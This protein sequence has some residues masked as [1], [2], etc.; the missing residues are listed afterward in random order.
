MPP[1]PHS[2]TASDRRWRLAGLGFCVLMLALHV[3]AGMN[4][5]GLSDFWRDFYWATAIAHGEAFPLAGPQIYQ[6]FEL[7][8][9]WFYL[10]ALPV[11]ATGS[12]ALTM[13]FVQALASL[14]YFL[15]WRIGTRLVDARFG[16]V[17]AASL[18]IA[19]WSLVGL[20]FPSHV[21]LIETTL[22]LLAL[23]VMR[24]AR[25]F[26][27]VEAVLFGLAAAAC[28]HAHPTTLTYVAAAGLFLLWRHRS[29]AVFGWLCVAA[30]IVL[31]S[32]LPPWLHRDPAA[33][34][35]LKPIGDYV[36]GD[37]GRHALAR[38]P[39]VAWSVLLGG[40]WWELLLMTPLKLAAARVAWWVFGVCLLVAAAGLWRA[41]GEAGAL[42]RA[43]P[44]LLAA[45]AVQVSFVVLLRPVTPFWMVPACLPPLA[46]AIAIGWHA[47][48]V[49][50]RP[51]ARRAG[52][53]A[54][55]VYFV[56]V[57]APF[58]F[59]LRDLHA[60]RVMPGV[61]PFF[62][63]IERS[64]RYVNVAVP[65]YPLRRLDR[66]AGELCEPAVLHARLV[67]LAENSFAAPLRNHCGAW[68]EVRYGGVEGP[69]RHLAGLSPRAAVASGI[70]P[71]RV[72]AHMA[73]YE[74]VRPIAPASGGTA[75]PPRR[76]QITPDSAPG[77]M[78]RAAFDFE[79][80]GRD[81][82]V[83]TNRLPLLA[84][85]TDVA[86]SAAGRPARLLY[87]DGNSF[88]YAC[89]D[90]AADAAANWHVELN[91]IAGNLDLIVLPR[92]AGASA[93]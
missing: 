1:R 71:A 64:D 44:W 42:R 40:A 86:V 60:T 14:K 63:I 50:A 53:V 34:A 39:Q 85:M 87:D 92:D 35:A 4:S 3:A 2:A 6:L 38:I 55:T 15:A 68:P 21:A 93:H 56:L 69:Q 28:L 51:W 83:L 25:R 5:A 75:A 72:V 12:V 79:S 33:A 43:W 61:N 26:G 58:P 70:A 84:S 17:F 18:V 77:P 76:L 57:L 62:D 73:I 20:L 82:F 9:W 36:G 11:A 89:A 74:R 45:F 90:C 8:P 10:L 32:L 47:W 67:P 91:G 7:G 80:G 16:F 24:G 48:Q 23:V 31:A 13:A 54:M 41:R 29:A 59:W 46:A 81:V 65:F 19:G 66:L 49:D 37:V 22:L 52:A 78:V 30:L 88:V 27:A